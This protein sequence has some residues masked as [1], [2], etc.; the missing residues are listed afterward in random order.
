MWP[1]LS[2]P[3]PQTHTCTHMLTMTNSLWHASVNMA[4][5]GPL[6]LPRADKAVESGTL[7]I[8]SL[9]LSFT[10]NNSFAE[11]RKHFSKK[12]MAEA[13]FLRVCSWRAA[14]IDISPN[15]V[16]WMCT[17]S[18][19]VKGYVQTVLMYIQTR[20]QDLNDS[21]PMETW[22]VVWKLHCK[23]QDISFPRRQRRM[24]CTLLDYTWT[25]REVNITD[26]KQHNIPT[27]RQHI[28]WHNHHITGICWTELEG[29]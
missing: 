29:V 22:L 3:L 25:T 15:S 10:S 8:S 13:F 18:C 11:G 19:E 4:R 16:P 5:K 14:E 26:T 28:K 21:I 1:F 24:K 6:P 9:G 2:H 27:I 20:R 17:R 7:S 23:G 12:R